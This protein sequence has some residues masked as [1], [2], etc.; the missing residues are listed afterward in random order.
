MTEP[1]QKWFLGFAD[2]GNL[3]KLVFGLLCLRN[4]NTHCFYDSRTVQHMPLAIVW[5]FLLCQSCIEI[6]FV[7]DRTSPKMVFRFC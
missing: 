1:L 3:G 5:I 6:V 2:D 7:D 4:K